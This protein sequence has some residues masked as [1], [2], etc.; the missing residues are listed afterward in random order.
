M[1]GKPIFSVPRA[2]GS[3]SVHIPRVCSYSWMNRTLGIFYLQLSEHTFPAKT[4]TPSKEEGNGGLLFRFFWLYFIPSP[5]YLLDLKAY[6]GER[7]G[8]KEYGRI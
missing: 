3:G 4:N 1:S 5:K 2:L 7:W 8:G 6:G